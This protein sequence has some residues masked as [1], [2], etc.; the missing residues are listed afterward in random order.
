MR[1]KYKDVEYNT[2]SRGVAGGVLF[3]RQFGIPFAEA[4]GEGVV[5]RMD[6]TSFLAYIEL[7]GSG[8]EVGAYDEAFLF[9]LEFLPP[10]E[11]EAVAP[12]AAAPLAPEV[13]PG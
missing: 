1:V 5:P 8:V 9:N 7:K 6:W 13:Q 2:T 12:E 11:D 3:E 10:V 4:F